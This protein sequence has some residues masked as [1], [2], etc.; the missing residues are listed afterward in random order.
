MELHPKEA[1]YLHGQ[2]GVGKTTLLKIL[3]GLQQPTAGQLNL[4][5]ANFLQKI[6]GFS[7]QS[8]VI[9]MH[10]TPYLFDTSVKNNILYGLQGMSWQLKQHRLEFALETLDLKSLNH[11]HI[12]E[13]SGGEK[14]K[15]CHGTRLGQTTGSLAD[16]RSQRKLRHVW[17]SS[18][19]LFSR[20]PAQKRMSKL[21]DHQPLPN[22]MTQC[23]HQHWTL[24]KPPI[25]R[26]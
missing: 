12:S 24:E 18:T 14:A 26:I 17:H 1:V 4:N 16:G 5:K 9:Y 19:T 8:E 25:N 15:S 13:L 23:C 6:L 7:G 21:G 3:A 22:P 2:N 10:Q 11:K 20:R